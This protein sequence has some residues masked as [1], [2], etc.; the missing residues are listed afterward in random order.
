MGAPEIDGAGL[1][2]LIAAPQPPLLLDVREPEEFSLGVLEGALLL[3]MGRLPA[4]AG[5]ALPDKGRPVVVV[6]AHGNRSLVAANWLISKG[7]EGAVSLAGGMVDW[8]AEGRPVVR[9]HSLSDREAE[10]YARHVAIPEVGVAGQERL[11]ASSALLVGAGGLGCPGALYLAA[12]GVGRLGVLDFDVVDRSNLQRQVLYGESD[13]GTPKAEAAARRLADLN[14]D[15]EVVG[16]DARLVA[17]NVEDLVGGWDVVLD[18]ADNFA[19]RYLVSDASAR[20]GV[21]NVHGSV[22]RFEG[23]VSVFHPGAGGPCYR[24][25]FPEPPP[26]GSTPSCAE[27]GVLGVLPGLVGTLQAV[28]AV[29][30]LLGIGD[31]L[32]GRLLVVDALA[33]SYRTLE[34][35]KDPA[36]PVCAPGAE[37]PGYDD[38]AEHCAG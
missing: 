4:E 28:E 30:L 32:V 16:L 34:V 14:P 27:A 38:L 8:M 17:A 19:A 3:P 22:H 20:L 35:A 1:A 10:R 5:E 7:W 26:P 2:A 13:L 21:P 29:K 31:P 12:A 23:Q 33:A 18:G 6:C 25:L 37:F 9:D 15:I 24:C 36:C 11:K